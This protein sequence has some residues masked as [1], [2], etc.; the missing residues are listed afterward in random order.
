MNRSY[1]YTANCSY[2]INLAGNPE[3]YAVYKVVKNKLYGLAGA[4]CVS[5]NF[6]ETMSL[7]DANVLCS[8]CENEGM[9]HHIKGLKRYPEIPIRNTNFDINT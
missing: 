2:H 9:A 6:F 3:K 5:Q 7:E 4:G 8:I 1:Q